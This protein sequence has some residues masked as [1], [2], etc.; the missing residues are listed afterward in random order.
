[1]KKRILSLLLALLCLLMVFSGCKS[2]PEPLWIVID[3]QQSVSADLNLALEDLKWWIEYETG[4]TETDYVFECIPYASPYESTERKTAIDRIRTE[5]MSG[6]GPDV[7]IVQCDSVFDS[8]LFQMP[9][10]AMELG[11]FLPLDEYIENAEYA[12]WDKFTDSV[13]A[14]GR[15]GEGQQLVPLSYLLPAAMYRKEDVTHTPTAMT[16]DEMQECEELQDAYVRLGAGFTSTGVFDFPIEYLLGDLADYS[17]EELLF[18]E[19]ELLNYAD[20]IC[21]LSAYYSEN[22][23]AEK[24][25]CAKSCLGVRFNWTGDIGTESEPTVFSANFGMLNG[26]SE[27]EPLTLVPLC[28]DD[29]GCTAVITSFAAVN[30]NTRHPEEAF[31]VLDLLLETG[32]QADSS[33]YHDFIYPKYDYTGMPMHE[34]LMSSQGVMKGTTAHNFWFSLTDEDFASVCSV[35]D[36]ITDV[37]FAGSLN[38]ELENM[39]VSCYRAYLNGEDYTD[40]VHDAYTAMKQMIAE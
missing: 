33:L 22:N 36:Q 10:K 29:G 34:E 13:M 32:R 3:L 38:W 9:E 12:E 35:R 27:H 15:N 23:L 39:M 18:T 14:A 26:L 19:E 25:Y 37:Q 31:K 28:S 5:I 24:P 20:T 4:L 7:F 1:M 11:L 17:Q 21:E 16:W 6:G 2:E 30:R 40:I 8:L